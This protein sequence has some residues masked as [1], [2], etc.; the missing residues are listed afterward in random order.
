MN[1]TIRQAS[2]LPAIALVSLA[3]AFVAG[4]AGA[5]GPLDPAAA[6]AAPVPAQ[7]AVPVATEAELAAV[8]ARIPGAVVQNLRATPIPGLYELRQGGDVVYVT[9]DGR[10]GFSGEIYRLADKANLTE[11]RRRALRLELINA[12]PESSMVVFSPPQPKY[13]VTVFTDVDCQ[14]CRALHQQIAE[15]NRL[16]V[17]VRYLFFPR[18][19][20]DTESWFKAEQVWCSTDRKAALTQAKQGQ[21]LQAKTCKPNPIAQGYELGRNIGLEGTPGI[22]T[23]SGELLPGYAPPDVLVQE[24]ERSLKGPAQAVPKG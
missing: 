7:P 21:P 8:A 23:E 20:P 3:T 14:Y 6:A 18:T 4:A 24:I 15:Y 12:M 17:K 19:G 5:A 16:G 1:T 2:L 10:Y 11:Q 22:V 9:A 13:T